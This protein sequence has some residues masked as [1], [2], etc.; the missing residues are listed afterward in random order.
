MGG[1]RAEIRKRGEGSVNTS[2]K[3]AVGEELAPKLKML[4]LDHYEE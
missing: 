2:G 3:P 4:S 1:S